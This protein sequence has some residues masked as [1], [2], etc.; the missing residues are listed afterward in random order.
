MRVVT[1]EDYLAA[2]AT[3]VCE[4]SPATAAALGAVQLAFGTG[5]RRRTVGALH[6]V[7]AVGTAHEP[8][9]LV[10]IAAIGGLAPAETC[11]VVLRNVAC[12]PGAQPLSEPIGVAVAPAPDPALDGDPV[13]G[14]ERDGLTKLPGGD[15]LGTAAGDGG[16]GAVTDDVGRQGN[17]EEVGDGV[18]L[19]HEA[20]IGSQRLCFLGQEAGHGEPWIALSRHGSR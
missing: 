1:H 19:G 14:E 12:A 15:H 16:A 17:G 10:E 4:Q 8:L 2:V 11:H 20:G 5:P 18:D 13:A 6:R 3:A 9:P 7:W